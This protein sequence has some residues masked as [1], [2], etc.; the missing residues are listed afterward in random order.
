MLEI[1][2]LVG[3]DSRRRDVVVE[4]TVL[5]VRHDEQAAIPLRA[6]RERGI[7]ARDEC[8]AKLRIVI[9]V[10]VVRADAKELRIDQRVVRQG[11][12]ARTLEE[13]LD[14]RCAV[15]S[16]VAGSGPWHIVEVV[17]ARDAV[18]LETGPDVL[19]VRDAG[20]CRETVR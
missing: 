17:H 10:I 3:R 4:S 18:V 19:E 13:A 1:R 14:G 8:L 20:I 7:D 9:G 2:V 16:R 11:A 5:V 6:L 12:F 15:Q